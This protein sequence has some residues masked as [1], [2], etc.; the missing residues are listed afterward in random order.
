LLILT[1]CDPHLIPSNNIIENVPKLNFA[2]CTKEPP[3]ISA[4]NLPGAYK[5]VSSNVVIIF[6]V[7]LFFI[8][9]SFSFCT[10]LNPFK[11]KNNKI[12]IE[13]KL[14]EPTWV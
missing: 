3:N 9:I 7:A 6:V 8:L 11:A 12:N 4:N 5:D 1:S 14:N 2:L 10:R 13:E